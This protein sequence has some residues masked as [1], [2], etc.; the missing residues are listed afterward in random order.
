MNMSRLIIFILAILTLVIYSCHDNPILPIPN[1][2]YSY[3][4]SG[5]VILQNQNENSNALIYIDN[6]NRGVSSDSSGNYTF[7]FNQGDSVYNGEFKIRYFLNDYDMDSAKIIL[8]KGKLKL[9]TLDVDSEGKIKTKEL[10]QIVLIEGWTDKQVYKIGE[11]ITFTARVTNISNRII[12]VFIPSFFGPLGYVWL[13]TEIYPPNTLSPIDPV[14]LDF[15]DNLSPKGYYEG[16]VTYT[17][18]NGYYD[19]SGFRTLLPDKYIVE[20]DFFIEG[21]LL[22]QFQ[23]TFNKYI[24]DEWYKIVRGPSPKEDGVPNKYKFPTI[25]IIE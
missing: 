14:T 7:I 3:K 11:K 9:D 8:L 16:K 2:P 25:T 1:P 21:R 15:D 18:P 5:K 22:N 6:L 24:M 4:L 17:I 23:S 13:Y 20:T 12:H 19:G 10:K